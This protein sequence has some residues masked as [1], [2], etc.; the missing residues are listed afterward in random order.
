MCLGLLRA[1]QWKPSSKVDDVLRFAMQLLSEPMPE[2]AVEASI[3][4]EYK[5][6]RKGWEKKAKE[7]TKRYAV[8]IADGAKK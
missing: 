2:D 3:A 7:W 8:G 5:N 6:D 1:E 4:G